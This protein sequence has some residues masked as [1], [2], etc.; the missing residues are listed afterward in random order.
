MTS[1]LFLSFLCYQELIIELKFRK[2][3]EVTSFIATLDSSGF[4]VSGLQRS[5]L[6]CLEGQMALLLRHHRQEQHS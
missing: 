3:N 5:V 6:L 4:T 2:K 1:F